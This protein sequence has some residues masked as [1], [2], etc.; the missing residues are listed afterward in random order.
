MVTV[1]GKYAT[2]FRSVRSA[3]LTHGYGYDKNKTKNKKDRFALC[4]NNK[5]RGIIIYT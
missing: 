5:I 2:Q 4:L 3:W 1:S